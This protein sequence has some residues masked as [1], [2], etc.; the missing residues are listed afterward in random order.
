MFCKK[1]VFRN[2]AK[3]NEKHLCQSLFF[4]KVAGLSCNF[5]KKEIL[6][7]VFSCEF[8]EIS[9]N[10]FFDR[11]PLVAASEYCAVRKWLYWILIRLWFW[12]RKILTNWGNVLLFRWVCYS[13]SS[14]LNLNNYN[15]SFATYVMKAVAWNY[16]KPNIF[17]E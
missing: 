6:V 8:C 15:K 9:K 11:T 13:F 7:Q 4:N 2:F 17:I 5:I 14:H 12:L 16:T 3:F 10:T 1:G